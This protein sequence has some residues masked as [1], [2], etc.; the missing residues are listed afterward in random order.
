[1]IVTAI[2][3]QEGIFE[4]SYQGIHL[5][6]CCICMVFTSCFAALRELFLQPPHRFYSN[7]DSCIQLSNQISLCGWQNAQRW[8]D[9]M[10]SM[11]T[12]NPHIANVTGLK[13]QL[14]AF[15]NPQHSQKQ[16]ISQSVPGDMVLCY[17]NAGSRSPL[18]LFVPL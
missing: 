10:L 13:C 5:Y 3:N 8:L 17:K 6:S 9:F 12:Y 1:M 18:L 16:C 7:S 15:I 4:S 11:L 14:E 2:V